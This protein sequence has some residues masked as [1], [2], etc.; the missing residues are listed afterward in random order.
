M[1]KECCLLD[2]HGVPRHVTEGL[3]YIQNLAE[4]GDQFSMSIFV[5]LKRFVIG[6]TVNKGEALAFFKRTAKAGRWFAN[7]EAGIMCLDGE[8]ID[9]NIGKAIIHFEIL[10]KYQRNEGQWNLAV[11]AD[12]HFRPAEA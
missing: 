2:C 12:H 1:A 8:D 9:V 11:R 5:D 4:E 7:F 10:A 3:R 6:T